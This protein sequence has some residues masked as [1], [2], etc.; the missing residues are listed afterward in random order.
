LVLRNIRTNA[1]VLVPLKTDI[2]LWSSGA[3]KTITESVLVPS[4][5]SA[6]DY[7]L[8]LNIPDAYLTNRPDYS[9]ALA[10]ENIWEASTGYNNL[11][12]TIKLF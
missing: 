3:V 1:V 12:H 6:G 8:L 7:K 5:T 10:N 11:L 2:R 9:L 4:T